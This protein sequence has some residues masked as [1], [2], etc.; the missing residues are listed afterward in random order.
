MVDVALPC[1]LK[2]GMIQKLIIVVFAVSLI[3]FVAL[4]G[5][6]PALRSLPG[7]SLVKERPLLNRLRKTPIGLANRLI[8]VKLPAL[9][10][11]LDIHLTGGR[12]TFYLQRGGHYLMNE[13]HP[14]V[15]VSPLIIYEVSTINLVQIFYLLLL[16]GSECIFLPSA[17]PRLSWH[18]RITVSLFILAPYYFTYQCVMTTSSRITSGNY[19]E[20]MQRYA[21]DHVLFRPGRTCRTCHLPKPARSK[22]CSICNACVAKHDHHCIWV[23]NCLGMK[24][25]AFF[26]GLLLSL[27]VLLS[28][29]AWL[30]YVLLDTLLQET[31][32]RRADGP[33]GRSHWSIGR[34]WS[35]CFEKWTLAIIEDFPIGGVGLL[36]FL[37]APLAGG[38]LIYHI[39][40]IWAGMTTNESFKWA[41]WKDDVTDGYVYKDQDYTGHGESAAN[42]QVDLP[43]DWPISR[44]QNLVN[45]TQE[46]TERHLHLQQPR[47]R[48]VTGLDE[49]DNIYDLGFLDNLR[50]VFGLL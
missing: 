4:F 23:M 42:A 13:N 45:L 37:T 38:L 6:L 25:Y 29:G 43:T 31:L 24:N 15:L 44:R 10:L 39:Y 14:L 19:E 20:H 26:I 48:K 8:W 21:Y 49:L 27:S 40:L 12:C 50:E 46:G 2:M 35:Q 1:R 17:W 47:W 30:S 36:A 41:E 9:L 7:R 34:T 5:R 3:T 16:L 33:R 22:H 32:L 28:Y 18:H 11:N